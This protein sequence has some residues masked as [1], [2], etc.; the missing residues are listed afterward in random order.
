VGKP[1]GFNDRLIDFP[2]TVGSRFPNVQRKGV[3]HM[4]FWDENSG[5]LQVSEKAALM[6]RMTRRELLAV[7]VQLT[8]EPPAWAWQ[9]ESV[10]PLPTFAVPGGRL[11]GVCFLHGDHLHAVELSVSCVGQRKR[12]TADQQRAL[13]FECLRAGDPSR[14]SKRGVLLRCPFGTALVGT[15]PRSGDATLR[16]T[17]R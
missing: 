1:S 7:Y 4:Q 9:A 16:F 2:F 15:D 10:L 5:M 13:L 12:G 11:A 3:C 17:Y 14:D 6:P 8:G